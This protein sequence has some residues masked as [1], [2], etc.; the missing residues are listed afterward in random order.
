[1]VRGESRCASRIRGHVHVRAFDRLQIQVADGVALLAL[2][3]VLRQLSGNPLD[4]SLVE[5][6]GLSLRQDV[7]DIASECLALFGE[8]LNALNVGAQF[9][10]ID[11]IAHADALF[12]VAGAKISGRSSWRGMP[13]SLS[14]SATRAAGIG[15]PHLVHRVTADLCTPSCRASSACAMPLASRMFDSAALIMVHVAQLV[16]IV[17]GARCTMR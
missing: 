2:A 6:V 8:A 9:V 16:A 4:R 15:I 7:S 10:V 17:N 11:R 3:P 12:E 13:V 1:M 14:M 5:A